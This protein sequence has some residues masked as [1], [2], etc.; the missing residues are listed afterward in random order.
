[1]IFINYVSVL[2]NILFEMFKYLFLEM[3]VKILKNY[4]K[5]NNRELSY[6]LLI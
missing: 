2:S 1:M 6:D 5:N 3:C 4:M